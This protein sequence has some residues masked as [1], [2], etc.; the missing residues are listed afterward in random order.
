M[1]IPA[2]KLFV[3]AGMILNCKK[4]PVSPVQRLIRGYR[5][6]IDLVK[7]NIGILS[8]SFKFAYQNFHVPLQGLTHLILS[9]RNGT[10]LKTL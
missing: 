7:T 5:S 6:D 4:I 10:L 2:Q 3:H 8:F 9:L 1:H